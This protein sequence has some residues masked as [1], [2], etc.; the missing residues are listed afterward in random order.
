MTVPGVH[1]TPHIG[2]GIV[3]QCLQTPH[4]DDYRH[5]VYVCFRTHMYA[6]APPHI[7]NVQANHNSCLDNTAIT[8]RPA[9]IHR[10]SK[11]TSSS[12]SRLQHCCQNMLGNRLAGCIAMHGCVFNACASVYVTCTASLPAP[13]ALR[14][15]G[16]HI[17]K[18]RC[19]ERLC[20][21]MLLDTMLAASLAAWWLRCCVTSLLRHMW[22][23]TRGTGPA[24]RGT[25]LCTTSQHTMA[26]AVPR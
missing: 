13:G 26:Q 25:S 16:Y 5:A 2:I 19:S 6:L 12:S 14:R 22:I 20:A 10:H 21:R 11:C 18:V 7:D 8:G 24:P 3:K 15:H 9:L 17:L 1:H 23:C 4:D